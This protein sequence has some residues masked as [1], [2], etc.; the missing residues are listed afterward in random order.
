MGSD[1]DPVKH[2]KFSLY[3]FSTKISES[4]PL[5]TLFC[6]VH[7]EAYLQTTVKCTVYSI[8]IISSL[9]AIIVQYSTV[10]SV[11][12]VRLAGIIFGGNIFHFR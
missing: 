4:V 11:H 2:M 10:C 9:L 3:R 5:E 6:S 8:A 7:L 12:S 1:T